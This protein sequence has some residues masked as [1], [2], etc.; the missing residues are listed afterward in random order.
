VSKSMHISLRPGEKLYLN[1]AV[2]RA[3]RKMSLELLNDATFL[4]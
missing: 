3:D 4:L 1:G 2:L